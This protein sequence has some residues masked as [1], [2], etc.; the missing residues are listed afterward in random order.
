M[1][2]YFLSLPLP[3]SFAVLHERGLFDIPFPERCNIGEEEIIRNT[4]KYRSNGKAKKFNEPGF[5]ML[6]LIAPHSNL[7]MKSDLF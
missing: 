6:I 1:Y 3:F 4:R 2:F 5:N 7:N